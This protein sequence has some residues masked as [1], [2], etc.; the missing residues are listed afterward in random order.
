MI[1]IKFQSVWIVAN[2]KISK[3]WSDAETN[4]VKIIQNY[5]LKAFQK[6]L[7]ALYEILKVMQQL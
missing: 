2:V 5:S 3:S 6:I 1:E 7:K 4:K